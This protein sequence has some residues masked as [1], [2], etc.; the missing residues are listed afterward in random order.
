MRRLRF[1]P[2]F[3]K[4]FVAE[5]VDGTRLVLQAGFGRGERPGPGIIE[6]PLAS[7]AVEVTLI[8]AA[9]SFS[10][11]TIVVATTMPTADHGAAL[12]VHFVCVESRQV[13]VDDILDMERA[14]LSFL[15]GRLED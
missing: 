10:P 14:L 8:T 13:A 5:I 9:V 4:A 3:I 12:Y 1:L 15:H 2:A 7:T 6:I 11:G